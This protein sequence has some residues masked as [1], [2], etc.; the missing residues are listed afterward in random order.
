[1]AANYLKRLEKFV[2]DQN[3]PRLKL[4][5]GQYWHTLY[6]DDGTENWLRQPGKQHV[7][8]NFIRSEVWFR[9]QIAEAKQWWVKLKREINNQ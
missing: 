5:K 4:H 9:T 6:Y 3:D 1:M 7:I 2:Q 8:G